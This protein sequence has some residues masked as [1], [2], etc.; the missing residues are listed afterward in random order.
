MIEASGLSLLVFGA[1]SCRLMRV[2]TGSTSL[3]AVDLYNS[4]SGSW[5]T[6]RLSVARYAIAATSVGNV[7]IFGGG[8]S[9]TGNWLCFET[10][11]LSLLVS[12]LQ[13]VAI[14]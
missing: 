4:T 9:S 6:A 7:A 12:S 1:A 10:S 3:D 11:G 5:S 2:T 13:Q 14:S 8:D